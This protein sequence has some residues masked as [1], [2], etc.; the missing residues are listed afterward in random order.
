MTGTLLLSIFPSTF[1]AFTN[2]EAPSKTDIY[3]RVL[4]WK[5]ILISSAD[6]DLEISTLGESF[7]VENKAES[8]AMQA[9]VLFT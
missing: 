5:Y 2:K 4:I 1:H 3:V 6:P 8:Q 7:Q 9:S